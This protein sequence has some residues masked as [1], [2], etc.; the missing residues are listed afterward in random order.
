MTKKQRNLQTKLMMPFS[1]EWAKC[2]LGM[3]KEDYKL[4]EENQK[5]LEKKWKKKK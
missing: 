5:K 4:L 3:L 2:F 1:K